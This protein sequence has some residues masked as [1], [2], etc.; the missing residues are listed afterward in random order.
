M[1]YRNVKTGAVIEAASVC[2]GEDWVAVEPADNKP[3][4]K[5]EPAKTKKKDVKANE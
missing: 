2:S 5:K 3:A 1:Q 4:T